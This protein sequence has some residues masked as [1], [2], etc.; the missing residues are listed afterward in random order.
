MRRAL[1]PIAALVL[2]LGT[3]GNAAASSEASSDHA[4]LYYVSVGDSQAA[5]VQPIDDPGNL[6]RT[7]DCYS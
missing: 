5:S 7:P 1:A 6:Y 4:K 2:V 3:V